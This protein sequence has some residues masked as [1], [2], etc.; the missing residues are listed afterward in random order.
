MTPGDETSRKEQ[1][2]TSLAALRRAGRMDEAVA[3]AAEW[4]RSSPDE[5][6]AWSALGETLAASS[7]PDLA[8]KAWAQAVK[9]D[10]AA[11]PALCGHAAA[12]TALGRPGEAAAFYE[13]ALERDVASSEARFGLAVLAFDSGDLDR[14]A[15]LVGGLETESAAAIWLTARLGVARGEFEPAL[16]AVQ[17]LLAGG[18][19]IGEALS[20]AMLLQAICLDRLDRTAAAFAAATCGK[21]IQRAHFAG[22][23]AGHEGQVEKFDRL[24]DWFE[25]ADRTPWSSAP[26]LAPTSDDPRSHVFLVGFPRSGTTLLEQALA[27]HSAVVAL[28]EAPSLA[29]AYQAFLKTP[30]GLEK[31]AH[32]SADDALAWRASYWQ[33]VRAHG[34]A[35]GKKVFLDKAPAETLSLPVI[36]KLFP[37]AKVLFAVRDP[38]DVILSCFMNSF[39]MN[40]MTYAFTDLGGAAAC[41]AACMRLAEVYRDLLPLRIREVRY[42]S[43]VEDFAG[44][45]AE[46]ADFLGIEFTPSMADVAAASAGRVVRTPSAARIRAGLDRRGLARW[47]AYAAELAPVAASLA[48]WITRFGYLE[49]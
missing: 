35:P 27:G 8:A 41:Y 4:T 13:R 1:R 33:V 46:I 24:A 43:L 39:Q 32:I 2:L 26:P 6:A 9:L 17:T 23:A 19:L 21:A 10:P 48:P 31:L 16:S 20:E 37:D 22:R 38:R 25:A 40:A 7:R 47:R 5:L 28:E 45:L 11:I 34:A 29:D 36:A 42:E 14:A 44:K 18:R 49:D 12:L 3:L 15:A 30:Q